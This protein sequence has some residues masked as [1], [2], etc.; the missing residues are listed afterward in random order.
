MYEASHLTVCRTTDMKSLMN[1][2]DSKTPE[3]IYNAIKQQENQ[4]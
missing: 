2:T 4:I 1:G 3:D